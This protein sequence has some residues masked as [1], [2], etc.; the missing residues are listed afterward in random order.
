MSA[1]VTLFERL[2][3]FAGDEV[4]GTDF[5]TLRY[6]GKGPLIQKPIKELFEGEDTG[7]QDRLENIN[8]GFDRIPQGIRTRVEA[9]LGLGSA[10]EARATD[11]LRLT[12]FLFPKDVPDASSVKFI[13]KITLVEFLKNLKSTNQTNRFGFLDKIDSTVGKAAGVAAIT[14]GQVL[15][16]TLA[17][18]GVI[19]FL[20]PFQYASLPSDQARPKKYIEKPSKETAFQDPTFGSIF[21]NDGTSGGITEPVKNDPYDSQLTDNS[22]LALYSETLLAD[23]RNTQKNTPGGTFK[24]FRNLKLQNTDNSR[25]IDETFLPYISSNTLDKRFRLPKVRGSSFG[26]RVPTLIASIEDAIDPINARDVLQVETANLGFTDIIPFNIQIIEPGQN[27]YWIFLRAHLEDFSDSFT[28]GWSPISYLGR[29][30]KLYTYKEF[31]RSISF[32]LKIA[33]FTRNEL[34]PLYNKMNFLAGA[35]AGYYGDNSS[36]VKGVLAKVTIGDY[37]NQLPGFFTSVTLNWTTSYPW[38]IRSFGDIDTIELTESGDEVVRKAPIVPH[39]LDM[40]LEFKPVHNFTPQVKQS[41]ILNNPPEANQPSQDNQARAAGNVRADNSRLPI[42]TS[43]ANTTSTPEQNSNRTPAV[44]RTVSTPVA[45][46]SPKKSS[47]P[48]NSTSVPLNDVVEASTATAPISPRTG[49]VNTNLPPATN[50]PVSS[51]KPSKTDNPISK[52]I[53]QVI[54]T[55]PAPAAP[56]NFNTKKLPTTSTPSTSTKPAPNPFSTGVS[57]PNITKPALPK[58]TFSGI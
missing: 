33:A 22:S 52:P 21:V 34:F 24:D 39:I 56:Y 19:G 47:V 11:V 3:K 36:F 13:S 43:N 35:T 25:T 5:R 20:Q 40:S 45:S 8:L 41:F 57:T 53:Q 55:K 46:S 48:R 44:S 23:I 17:Q 6:V 42:G 14:T 27:P 51:A 1:P 30:E 37:I 10:V 54:G 38:E 50:T 12:K 9:A 7:N 31:D 16:T 28:G 26:K 29:S 2:T 58:T 32:K 49:R 4:L 15:A 18:A